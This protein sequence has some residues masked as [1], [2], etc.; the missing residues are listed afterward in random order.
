MLKQFVRVTVIAN[1]GRR[2]I[3]NEGSRPMPQGNA[4]TNKKLRKF[5]PSIVY[6]RAVTRADTK[7]NM[8]METV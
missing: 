4:L 1:E 8:Y 7:S 6:R 2:Q 5:G 3:N